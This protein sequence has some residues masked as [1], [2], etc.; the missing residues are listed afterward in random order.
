MRRDFEI[1]QGIYLVQSP[2]ELDLH[3]NF[4]FLGLDYSVE[5]RTL[6]LHWRRSRGEWVA[7]STPASVTIEFREVSE[8][9]FQPRDSAQPFTEDDCVSSF[10]Y[11]TDEDWADG[12]IIADPSQTPDP[13]WLTAI[14]FMSG[15]VIAVQA[16]SA[17]ARIEV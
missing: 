12:V 15:A 7:S 17:H 13:K 6:L 8:F 3:N 2:H 11:W 16:A 1:T 4:D 5:L 9:R 10:G 14:D